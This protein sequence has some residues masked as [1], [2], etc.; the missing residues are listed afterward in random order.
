MIVVII[1]FFVGYIRV[2]VPGVVT[3]PAVQAGVGVFTRQVVLCVFWHST[4]TVMLQGDVRSYQRCRGGDDGGVGLLHRHTG[5][6]AV[7]PTR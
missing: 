4:L 2:A 6:T 7:M 5:H 3:H 1:K